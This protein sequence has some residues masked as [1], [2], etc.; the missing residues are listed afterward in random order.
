MDRHLTAHDSGHAKR[1]GALKDVQVKKLAGVNHGEI[2][3]LVE[4]PAQTFHERKRALLQIAAEMGG[5]LEELKAESIAQT[6]GCALDIA[7]TR[8]GAEQAKRAALVEAD[9]FRYGVEAALFISVESLK[10][11]ECTI[12]CLH[13][14]TFVGYAPFGHMESVP[15]LHQGE[16]RRMQMTGRTKGKPRRGTHNRGFRRIKCRF[17]PGRR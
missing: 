5:T 2:Y 16:R 1:L 14:I 4:I 9:A 8:E 13:D 15:V 12:N 6:V 7:A 17:R 3:G 10:H 11:I